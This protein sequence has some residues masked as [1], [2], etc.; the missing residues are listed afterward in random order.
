MSAGDLP[1]FEAWGAICDGELVASLL[2]FT[3]DNWCT[4]PYAQSSS[5]HLQYRV[6]NG[7]FYG[8]TSTVL[9]RPGV[10]KMFLGLHSLD[11]PESVDEF[12][13]RMGYAA[14]PV[15]QRVV[16]HPW[17]APLVNRPIHSTLKQVLHRYPEHP[18]LSKAEGMLRF[19]LEGRCPPDEQ[20]W[21]ECLADRKEEC[22]RDTQSVPSARPT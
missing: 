3:C 13:F 17:L 1:G 7:L 19:C 21:P 20:H 11:A 8:V 22:M 2:A 10:D 12:K 18:A 16:F 9:G 14:R 4:I 15:R 6:N 5:D